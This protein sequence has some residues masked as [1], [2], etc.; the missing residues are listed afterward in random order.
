MK[1]LMI[2]D[3]ETLKTTEGFYAC[4]CCCG[5]AVLGGGG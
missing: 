1:R 2:R 4:T 3:V 5:C